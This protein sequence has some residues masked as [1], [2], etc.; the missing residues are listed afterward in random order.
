MSRKA[1]VDGDILVYQAGFAAEERMYELYQVVGDDRVLK[2]N[3]HKVAEFPYKKDVLTFIEMTGGELSDFIIEKKQV[4]QPVEFAYANIK[5]IMKEILRGARASTY[6]I[7]LTGDGN[8]RDDIATIKKYKGNR[9]ASHKPFHFDAI[10]HYLVEQWG[11]EV[12]PFQE[13]DDAMGI[14]QDG[15]ETII[16]TIDKD[17]MMI[18]GYHYN[19]NKGFT[20]YMDTGKAL[21]FFYT[22]LITGDTVDNIQGIKGAGPAKAKKILHNL[23]TEG[24]Y[25]RAVGLAYACSDYDDPEA[26]LLENAR[27]LWIRREEGQMWEIP[28]VV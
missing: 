4:P 13:A 15:E 26:A 2:P 27:L 28:D 11:A 17:L 8:Y 10:R 22:Q 20:T 18:P 1:L 25:I 16:C 19:F 5:N 6:Q 23:D 9:D 3:P 12:V 21:N 24:E 7:Y 14:A